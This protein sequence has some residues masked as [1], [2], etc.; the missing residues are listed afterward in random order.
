MELEWWILHRERS[1][2][3]RSYLESALAA[4]QAG[5][6]QKPDSLFAA[7]AKAR[8]EAMLLRD[9]LAESGEVSDQ[10]WGRIAEMLNRSWV[11][12]QTAAAK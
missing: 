5:I 7:H 1:Q 3:P 9:A 10:D 11:S 6:Y 4:L 2:H 12:L 8:A